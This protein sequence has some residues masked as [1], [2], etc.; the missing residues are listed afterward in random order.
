MLSQQMKSEKSERRNLK[1]LFIHIRKCFQAKLSLCC[2]LK[3]TSSF[4]SVL[5]CDVPLFCCDYKVTAFTLEAFQSSSLGSHYMCT[6][7]CFEEN[8]HFM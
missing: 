7:F 6:V 3:I 8:Q 5:W 2:F 1:Q 4:G